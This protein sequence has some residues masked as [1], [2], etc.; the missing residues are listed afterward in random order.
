MNALPPAAVQGADCQAD[1]WQLLDCA[2]PELKTAWPSLWPDLRRWLDD[3]T[4]RLGAEV[5]RARLDQ[6]LA[7]AGRLGR[8]GR[9]AAPLLAALQGWPQALDALADEADADADAVWTAWHDLVRDWQRSPNAAALATLLAHLPDTARTCAGSPPRLT[10]WWTLLRRLAHET[11][12]SIHGHHRT[13]ASP[14]LDEA[15]ALGA[16]LLAVWPLDALTQWLDWGLRLHSGHPPRLRDYFAARSPDSLALLARLRPGTALETLQPRLDA[17]ARA[18]W[19]S[20]PLL[21]P[22]R[23]WGRQAPMGFV[24]C[25]Q[26][27]TLLLPDVL[28]VR[29]GV[30]A[31]TRYLLRMAHALGHRRHSTPLA[32]G[33]HSLLQRLAIGVFEDARIDTLLLRDLPGWQPLLRQLHPLPTPQAAAQGWP[34]RLLQLSA[35][36]M[37]W[38]PEPASDGETAGPLTQACAA[39]RQVLAD[40][41]GEGSTAQMARLAVDWLVA[42][43]RQNP[44]QSPAGAA[45]PGAGWLDEVSL[46]AV[47]YRDDNRLL[48]PILDDDNAADADQARS[49]PPDAPRLPPRLYPEWDEALGCDKPDWVSVHEALL[50]SASPVALDALLAG[51]GALRERLARQWARVWPHGR[52]RVRRL[53]RG[54]ELDLD[55]ALQA[56]T[57]WRCGLLPDER[58]EQHHRPDSRD[59]SVLI[60]LDLSASLADPLAPGEGQV[61]GG[62]NGAIALPHRLA[63]SQLAVALLLDTL[64]DAVPVAVAGF[65][66]NGR[67]AVHYWHIKGFDEPAAGAPRQRLAALQPAWSTR[68]GPA[69]RH[70]GASLLHQRTAARLLL[71]LTDGEPADIDVPP[72]APDLL[73]D[74]QRVVQQLRSQGLTVYG[75]GLE[76]APASADPDRIAYMPAIF[77]AQHS[78][79]AHPGDLPEALGQAV[80]RLGTGR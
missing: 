4:S 15:I 28:D 33:Q 56:A 65:H 27:D 54:S 38:W 73:R 62:L 46:V 66:S 29:D 45:L 51:Q 19:G 44:A 69:L 8:L 2:L 78:A 21:A 55:L 12:V 57:D 75:I 36:L 71:V 39:F 67:H 1:A 52:G 70:A 31:H 53:A 16:D 41:K 26:G 76:G 40:G 23:T 11:S 74:S 20:A 3:G 60:L 6:V 59:L 68:L 49:A 50:H 77:G 42:C 64:G 25:W 35:A 80:W 17:N 24:A 14:C 34:A 18:L 10:G 13:H 22:V 47:D 30:P 37:G 43:Q 72:G 58:I 79:L 63:L 5:A 61:A 9:G 48:W 7:E 32:A